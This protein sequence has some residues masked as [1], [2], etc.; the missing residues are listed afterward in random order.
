MLTIGV[1]ALQGAFQ[2]HID[3]ITTCGHLATAIRLP[4]ELEKV[5]GTFCQ[6]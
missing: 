3:M 4:N 6:T 1:I 2:E 5:D